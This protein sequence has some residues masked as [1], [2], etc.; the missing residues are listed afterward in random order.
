MVAGL[1]R[2]RKRVIHVLTTLDDKL[3]IYEV[4]KEQQHVEDGAVAVPFA[5]FRAPRQ[6]VSVRCHGASIVVS[7]SGGAVCML[8]AP[9]LAALKQRCDSGGLNADSRLSE[10][11]AVSTPHRLEGGLSVGSQPVQ[12]YLAHKKLLPP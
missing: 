5:S 2:E 11:S 3:L 4:A 7:C 6:I 9:F 12:G 10:S 1:S 8:S